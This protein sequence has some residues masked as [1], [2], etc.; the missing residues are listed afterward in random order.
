VRR[1]LRSRPGLAP[2]RYGQMLTVTSPTWRC[3]DLRSTSRGRAPDGPERV[4]GRRQRLSLRGAL[5][6]PRR[7]VPAGREIRP[8]TWQP[9]GRLVALMPLGVAFARCSP[10]RTRLPRP[11][12]SWR[13]LGGRTYRGGHRGWAG[14]PLRATFLLY[15]RTGEPCRVCGSRVRTQLSRTQLFWCGRCQRR[16][17][18]RRPAANA[19]RSGRSS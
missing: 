8:T 6:P 4:G 12:P 18:G 9:S 5:S 7:P 17:E 15:R 1:S 3:A 11:P 16:A 19:L 14:D 2:I 10:W 13:W